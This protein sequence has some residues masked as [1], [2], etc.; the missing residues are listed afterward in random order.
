MRLF[1]ASS[2]LEYVAID[3]LGP[4]TQSTQGHKFILVMTDRFSKLVRAVPMRSISALSVAKVFVRDWAFVYGPPAQLLSDN[5]RQFTAKLFQSVCRSLR[6]ANMFTTTYHPQTNGQVER[7]NR[8]LLAGLR[9]FVGEHPRRWHELTPALAFAYNT[10]VHRSTGVA[11]FDLVLSRPPGSVTIK[12]EK[13]M[14]DAPPPS[15][16]KAQFVAHMRRL[17][18]QSRGVLAKAQGRYK[19]DY[20][21]RVRPQAP[22]T[23]GDRVYLERQGPGPT[24]EPGERSRHKLSPK[25]DGPYP[26]VA[27]TE[28]TVTILRDGLNEKVSRDRVSKAPTTPEQSAEVLPPLSGDNSKPPTSGPE[29]AQEARRSIPAPKYA[30]QHVMDALVDYDSTNDTFK[31]RWNGCSADED[32]WEPPG[33]IPSNAM[34][35][36]FRSRHQRLPR[37]LRHFNSTN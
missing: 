8:T 33:H 15:H 12:P 7:F 20:D 14:H 23:A 29:Q 18:Q 5:G 2:P 22:I 28:H 27:S 21:K 32:T 11:P 9:A 1:P 10:Q 4:L 30:E 24:A 16:A 19:R 6:V 17:V 35:S 31:V 37:H 36:Y 3:I 25:A 34:A 13:D 26:V